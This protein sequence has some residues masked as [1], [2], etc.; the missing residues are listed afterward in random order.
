MFP[1]LSRSIRLLL[2]STSGRRLPLL[3]LS[4]LT[5]Q[6]YEE[7]LKPPN[8]LTIIFTENVKYFLYTYF[9]SLILKFL[10]LYIYDFCVT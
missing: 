8:I 2:R 1:F 5:L 10:I 9:N 7:F 3:C 4:G 6:R